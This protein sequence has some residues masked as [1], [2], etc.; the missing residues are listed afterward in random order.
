MFDCSARWRS[1]R[2]DR[3][4]KA[5]VFLTRS[6]PVRL[7]ASEALPEAGRSLIRPDS[8]ARDPV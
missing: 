3:A 5:A 4:L 6:R 1:L 8:G 7:R 2:A